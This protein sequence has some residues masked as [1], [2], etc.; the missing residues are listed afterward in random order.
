MSETLYFDKGG[1]EHTG[2]TLEVVKERALEIKPDA[3]IVASITGASA[4][5]AGQIFRG[6]GVRVVGVSL[7]KG[8]WD[9]KYG[10]LDENLAAQ[11]REH[12]VEFLPDE[13]VVPIIDTEK[14]D[15]ANAWRMLSQ[16]FKVAIQVA[17]MCVDTGMIAGGAEVI[18]TGGSGAGTDTAIVV[19]I[20]G[21]K[22]ILKSN[23][24]EIIA[25]PR[26]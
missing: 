14:P 10:F 20:R 11:A 1:P 16:G 24:T 15:I 5:K 17:S 12:G 7:Q 8:V 13:P 19:K 9:A 25:M 4:L 3:V 23:V 21:Y 18:A 2:I 6:T 26:E 22:D